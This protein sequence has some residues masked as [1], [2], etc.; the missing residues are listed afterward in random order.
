M[1]LE[2][3]PDNPFDLFN[4]WY[5]EA[6]GQEPRDPNAMALATVNTEGMPS[7]RMVLLKGVQNGTFVFFTSKESRKGQEMT[8]NP[9]VALC[10]YWKSLNR[11]IRVEG[12][13]TPID[14]EEAD[15]YFASRPVGAQIGAW[16]SKQSQLLSSREELEER[17]AEMSQR[18]GDDVIPRP[19]HWVGYQVMPIAIEFWADRPFRLHDRIVYTPEGDGS[20][21]Q[22]RLYPS[23]II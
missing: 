19:D 1:V 8:E 18:F 23:N 12:I 15:S 9:H 11:Q 5:Q 6:V 16:A 2:T 3:L 21:T 7:V 17:M 22:S 10:F 14:G 13:A 20:W 4:E